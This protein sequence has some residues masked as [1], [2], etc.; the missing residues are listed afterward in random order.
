MR[1]NKEGEE[2]MS[3]T[4]KDFKLEKA[5]RR[6]LELISKLPES[7]ILELVDDLGSRLNFVVEKS[8]IF[9]GFEVREYKCKIHMLD[10]NTITGKVNSRSLKRLSEV[11]T[12]DQSP[13]VV[14]YGAKMWDGSKKKT[15]IL[16]KSA[17]AW[18]D[19]EVE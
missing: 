14:V 4:V 7:E 19:P 8:G 18:I 17:I 12:N 16:S 13:F 1:C 15:F 10:G 3:R 5:R 9:N 2:I 6:L 11:F